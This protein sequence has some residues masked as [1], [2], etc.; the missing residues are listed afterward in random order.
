MA[1]IATRAEK[2]IININHKIN[3]VNTELMKESDFLN[4]I[5]KAQNNYNMGLISV[6]EMTAQI[7]EIASDLKRD[8]LK[9]KK[10]K[11]SQF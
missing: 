7:Q 4:Q 8:L 6:Y 3:G 1:K 2:K 10:D 5:D 11:F 9:D